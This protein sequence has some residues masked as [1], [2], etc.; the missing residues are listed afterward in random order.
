MTVEDL[1]V[2]RN[3]TRSDIAELLASIGAPGKKRELKIK[4]VQSLK[5]RTNRQG[6]HVHDTLETY[7]EF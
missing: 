2:K 4:S 3:I 5:L 1:K 6:H 7:G